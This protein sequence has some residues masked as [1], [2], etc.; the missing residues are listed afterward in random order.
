MKLEAFEYNLRQKIV[1]FAQSIIMNNG[2]HIPMLLTYDKDGKESG[3]ELSNLFSVKDKN[4]LY[5]VL[6]QY[7]K[8]TESVA[9]VLI[10]EAYMK[11]VSR[12]EYE[13]MSQEQIE[14]MEN[15]GISDD[16]ESIETLCV[17]W[18]YK[19]EVTTGGIVS[20]PY[21]KENGC[22]V[23][24]YANIIDSYDSETEARGRSVN[25]FD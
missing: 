3:S 14:M 13:G 21:N 22:I 10:N 15:M 7:L 12:E 19:N 20:S 1:P 24:D 18:Q 4:V 6:K 5:S 23:I 16:S 17:T 11:K 8:D 2:T 9:Y 25:L